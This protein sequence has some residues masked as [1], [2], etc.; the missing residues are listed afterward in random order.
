MASQKFI[1]DT[2][3]LVY[4]FDG[5]LCPLPMQEY[6]VLPSLG[7]SSKE[8]WKEVKEEAVNTQS[9][10][11]LVYMRLLFEKAEEKKVHISKENLNKLAKKII[12]FDGVETWFNRIN[13]F[14]KA[15]G[16]GKVKIKHYVISAGMLEVLEGI[17]IKKHFS[18]IFASAYHFD[19]HGRATFPKQL[20]TDTVKTQFLF[21][22]NKGKENISESINQH[23]PEHERAIPFSNIIYVGDGLTDV[24]SMTVTKQSGGHS[25][26]VYEKKGLNACRDL[27]KAERVHFIAPANY[28]ENSLLEK[29]MKLL[30]KSVITS[31]TYERELFFC[32]NEHNILSV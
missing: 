23:T 18:N 4:D 16:D 3:A 19:H 20:I 1:H 11:M 32:R 25:V 13:E 28:S 5:T 21:R 26:A 31:I 22:I 7:I 30:L 27:L 9:E 24:P 15:E 29:R 10:E 12:Y 14:V 17:T 2:I 8:F 6:T